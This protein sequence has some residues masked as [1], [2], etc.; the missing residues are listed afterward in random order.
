M[1]REKEGFRDNMALLNERFPEKEM[2]TIAD[3]AEFMGVSR[4]TARRHIVFNQQTNL[5]TKAEFARQIC[6]R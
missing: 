5:V 2:L 3:A 6:A 4:W 1:S